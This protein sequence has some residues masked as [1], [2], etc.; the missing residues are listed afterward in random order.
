MKKERCTVLESREEGKEEGACS[1]S[2]R[3]VDYGTRRYNESGSLQK[4]LF[5]IIMDRHSGKCRR[6]GYLFFFLYR[7]TTTKR[8]NN[9]M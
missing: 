2:G 1:V 3:Y 6:Q 7:R 9:R 4:K 5:Q 8:C